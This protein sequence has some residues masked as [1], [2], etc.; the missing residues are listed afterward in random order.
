MGLKINSELPF[1]GSLKTIEAYIFIEEYSFN[2]SNNTLVIGTRPYFN[3][4]D[5]DA[6]TDKSGWAVF[7][8]KTVVKQRPTDDGGVENYDYKIVGL[9]SMYILPVDAATLENGYIYKVAYDALKKQIALDIEIDE[10][11]IEVM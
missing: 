6:D 7:G 8:S 2:K 4:E 11:L 1:K 3:K 9:K 10:S 5:R